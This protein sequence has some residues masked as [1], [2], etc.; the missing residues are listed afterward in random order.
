MSFEKFGSV[1]IVVRFFRMLTTIQLH[2]QFTLDAGEIN[3]VLTHG[4][5]SPEFMAIHLP[6]T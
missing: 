1:C 4:M 2:C 6:H 3:D 5:L